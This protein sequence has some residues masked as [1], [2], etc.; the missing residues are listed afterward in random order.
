MQFFLN[1]TASDCYRTPSDICIIPWTL[2][3]C[4]GNFHTLIT[5]SNMSMYLSRKRFLINYMIIRGLYASTKN[6]YTHALP[7]CSITA[8]H[9]CA[10]TSVMC[11]HWKKRRLWFYVHGSVPVDCFNFISHFEIYVLSIFQS[12]SNSSLDNYF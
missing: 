8:E 11:F 5:L 3:P 10:Y 2:S 12:A 7:V 9:S 4:F 1:F 6:I